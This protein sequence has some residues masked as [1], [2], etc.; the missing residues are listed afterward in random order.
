MITAISLAS[1]PRFDAPPQ[2][3]A[4]PLQ[5]SP[6]NLTGHPAMTVPVGVG[7]DGLPLAVQV[8]GR[9]FDEPT[10]FRIGRAIETLSGWDQVR[11]PALPGSR[12]VSEPV[13]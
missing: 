3:L 2:A 13:T 7:S 5:A 8:V 11:L 9:P 4:W 6:F 1:A 12:D 10:V